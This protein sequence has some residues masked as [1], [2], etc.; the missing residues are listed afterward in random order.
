MTASGD[1]TFGQGQANFLIN[2]PEAVAQLVLT[3]MRLVQGQWFLDKT[4]GV[5]YDTAIFGKSTKLERDQ[6][7]RQAITDTE[8]VLAILAFSSAV[9]AP[10]KYVVQAR[11]NTIYG[12]ITV[13][14]TLG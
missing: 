6:A 14:A 13:T 10:R 5:P 1:Y 4:A 12:A 3:N 9:E 11:I 7:V 2:S 8:G